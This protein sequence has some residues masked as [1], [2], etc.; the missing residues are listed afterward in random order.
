MICFQSEAGWNRPAWRTVVGESE[1]VAT[2]SVPQV[3]D[4][5]LRRLG[6]RVGPEVAAYVLRRWQSAISPGHEVTP[7]PIPVMGGD[8]RTGVPTRRDVDPSQLALS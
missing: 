3:Q 7:T 2:L 5:L 6:L 4:V 8:A 1:S